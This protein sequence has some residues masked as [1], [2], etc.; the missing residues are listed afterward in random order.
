MATVL[1]VDDHDGFRS[2]AR[3]FLDSNGF[4]VV[5]EASSGASAV[6]ETRRLRPEIVLLDVQLPDCDGFDVTRQLLAEP[7]PPAIVL[8]S[9]REA[10][11]YG[12]SIATC[13]ARGFVTKA[14]LT[15]D[16]IRKLVE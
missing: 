10:A 4:E 2:F 13:G 15:G 6:S 5:G 9:S 14:Q 7:Q 8:I 11:D 12:S 16:A 1:V 3:Q